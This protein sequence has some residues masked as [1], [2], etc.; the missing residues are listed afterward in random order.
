MVE[1]YLRRSPLAHRGLPARALAGAA[2]R[3]TAGVV[4][5]ERPHRCQVNLRGRAADPVF[6]ARVMS[7]IALALPVVP[8]TTTS[9]GGITALWL[10][11][12][13]WLITARPGREAEIAGK[14][15]DAL[16]DQFAAVTDVTEARTVIAVA[17]PRARDLMA[18]ATGLDL[19]PRVFRAGLC[20]QTGVARANAI[21][22]QT[23]DENAPGGP[24][25]EVF[26]ANSFADYLWQ[27]LEAAG[28][29]F[30]IAIGE[31]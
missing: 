1:A 19:H 28:A 26:V 24:G 8:N 27:W 14:L 13:E 4:L 5:S 18:K 16:G 12:D 31:G 15:V 20:A 6:A 9:D 3:A 23:L 21:L 7:A 17:G 30:G 25:Y 2:A 11:P 29:D 10:G 22:L